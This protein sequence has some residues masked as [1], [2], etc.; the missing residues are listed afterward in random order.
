MIYTG[1]ISSDYEKL[2]YILDNLDVKFIT[3]DIANG[4]ISNFKT[5]C[6]N[7]RAKYL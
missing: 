2:V 3:V 4:Y 6:K 5:F 7:L 1:I